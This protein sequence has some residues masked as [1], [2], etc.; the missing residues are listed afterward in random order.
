MFASVKQAAAAGAAVA[1]V[2]WVTA[3]SPVVEY[4]Q[5]LRIPNNDITCR[6][7]NVAE[8]QYVRDADDPNAY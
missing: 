6:A 1:C 4:G 8:V 2:E 3:M 7:D 5:P